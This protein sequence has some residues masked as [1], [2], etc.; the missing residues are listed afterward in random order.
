MSVSQ[1]RAALVASIHSEMVK[2]PTKRVPH[3][4]ESDIL[5]TVNLIEIKL[6][7]LNK[8]QLIFPFVNRLKS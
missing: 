2:K 3:E 7:Q 5:N 6:Y 4:H 1:Q 8:E